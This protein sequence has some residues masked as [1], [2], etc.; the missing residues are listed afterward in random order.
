MQKC[1]VA[2]KAHRKKAEV[3]LSCKR[4]S[5]LRIKPHCIPSQLHKRKQYVLWRYE[6]RDGKWTKPPYSVHGGPASS[7]D[8]STWAAFDEAMAAY[9]RGGWDGIG[10]VPTPEEGIVGID[11]DHCRDGKIIQAWARRIATEID[12]YTE[13]SPSG[14]GLRIIALGQRPDTTRSKR[15]NIEI[16][17]GRTKEGKPGGRYLTVTGH[18]LKRFGA[19]IQPRQEQITALYL[20]ELVGSDSPRNGQPPA[21]QQPPTSV[22]GFLGSGDELLEAARAAANGTK[23]T[24]LWAGDIGGYPSRSEAD[25]ALCSM[26]AFWTGPDPARIDRL[27]RQSRLL[28]PKWQ[29]QDYRRGVIAKALEGRTQFYMLAGIFGRVGSSIRLVRKRPGRYDVCVELEI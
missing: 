1:R 20:R 2:G 7:T 15:G 23:F 27:F 25:L 10:Y 13:I 6:L 11:L 3:D 26:L 28:R 18:Q 14:T 8:P 19:D 22:R 24:R 12:S 21:A 9:R 4:P 16:Y 29:R 5:A 17:D